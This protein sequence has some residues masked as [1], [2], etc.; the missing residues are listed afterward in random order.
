LLITAISLQLYPLV[1]A[2]WTKTR[3]QQN[4]NVN[5]FSLKDFTLLL[6]N[7]DI[8]TGSNYSNT[9][10]TC[11]KCALAVLVAFSAIL[12]R[13][14]PLECLI[15]S[16]FGIVGFELN[17]QI[18][19]VHVNDSFGTFS[20][21]TFG[22][23]M[24][25]AL[26]FILRIKENGH[27]GCSTE[28]HPRNTANF[29]SVSRAIFG[30]LIIFLFF[31]C[32]AMDLNSYHGI[33]V[34][35]V[36]VGPLSII[37]SMGSALGAALIF[38]CLINGYIIARDLIHAPIAGA[39]I[40]GTSSFFTINP[41]ES[42]IIGF[43]GGALQTIIQNLIEKSNSRKSGIVSTVSWSLF[44]IQGLLGAVA[45][46]VFDDI[47]KRGTKNGL[48]YN[49]QTSDK[50]PIFLL[51]MALISAGIGLGTG[52]VSGIFACCF[53]SSNFANHFHDKNYWYNSDGIAYNKVAAIETRAAV[54]DGQ[55]P[56]PTPM[57]EE[58]ELYFEQM[59]GD[60]KDNNAYL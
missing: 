7:F 10:T 40:G 47:L 18:I 15:V 36:Y 35:N 60:V 22:G 29:T 9:I 13:A 45:A 12:G 41:G 11:F 21:F 39:I 4:P 55:G 8:P 32:L 16:L 2:F 3:I 59:D 20:I 49:A 37:L 34:F 48:N 58:D 5:D 42:I 43:V 25:L 54:V 46:V 56:T 57:D 28:R 6:S 38:T 19:S 1:N 23:F 53:S 44:G 51:I 52:V 14:G 17:R 50:N 24:G 33:N 31:P 30:V 27:D 26:G